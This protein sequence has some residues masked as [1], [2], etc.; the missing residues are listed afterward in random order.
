[1]NLFWAWVRERKIKPYRKSNEVDEKTN[2]KHEMRKE[3]LAGGVNNEKKRDYHVFIQS[4][5]KKHTYKKYG[6]VLPYPSSI[7]WTLTFR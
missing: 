2:E 4:S 5:N 3:T 1:L 6:P 7:S